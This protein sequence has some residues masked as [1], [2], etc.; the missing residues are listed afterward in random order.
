MTNLIQ[1]P[2]GEQPGQRVLMPPS[3]LVTDV[4]AAKEGEEAAKSDTAA[5]SKADLAKAYYTRGLSNWRKRRTTPQA[6]N[7]LVQ[8]LADFLEDLDRLLV[9][10]C[11]GQD[12]PE[13]RG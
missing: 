5:A 6:E 3:A 10:P 12:L 9:Q 1:A 4:P 7:L 8:S 13:F 11:A 2:K